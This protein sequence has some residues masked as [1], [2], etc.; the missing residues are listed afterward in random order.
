MTAKTAV[1]RAR[2]SETATPP[3]NGRE[4]AS[5]NPDMEAQEWLYNVDD[6][7]LACRGQRHKFPDLEA[8]KPLPKGLHIVGPYAE[9]VMEL[10]STCTR[11]GKTRRL[12]TAPHGVLDLPAHYSYKDPPARQ[13]RQPFKTPKGSGITGRQCLEETWRRGSEQWI[14]TATPPAEAD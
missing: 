9:G 13:G 12:L 10:V 8:G 14:A 11:C 2:F 3:L 4:P 1:P 5:S 6:A 7:I